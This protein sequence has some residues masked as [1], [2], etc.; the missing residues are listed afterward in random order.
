MH[1]NCSVA[2]SSL[3]L[4]GNL[5]KLHIATQKKRER[6][7]TKQNQQQKNDGQ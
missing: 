6:E 2:K 5:Y 3:S 1:V 7:K 4:T